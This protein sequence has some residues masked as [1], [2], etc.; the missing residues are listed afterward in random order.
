M[1]KHKGWSILSLKG[2]NKVDNFDLPDSINRDS[3]HRDNICTTFYSL[4]K[5]LKV[6]V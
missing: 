3:Y 4:Y 1:F 5:K 6:G 2:L